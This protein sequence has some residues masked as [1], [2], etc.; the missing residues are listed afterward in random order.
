MNGKGQILVVNQDGSHVYNASNNAFC[1]RAPSWS[2]DGRQIA[3]V[4]S[5]DGDWEIYVMAADGTGQQR[6]TFSPGIDRNP[7]WS[8]DGKYIAFESDRRGSFDIWLMRPD[9]SGQRAV[10]PR[11]GNEYEPTWS[12]DSQSLAF[13]IQPV[14]DRRALCVLGIEDGASRTFFGPWAI[15]YTSLHSIAWSPDGKRIAGAFQGGKDTEDCNGSGV[16]V[17]N[18]DGGGHRELL[19]PDPLKPRSG[20][21]RSGKMLGSGWYSD[22]SASQ[23]WIPKRFSG[24]SWLP[25]ASAIVFSSDM[26]ESGDF[27]VYLLPVEGDKPVKLDGTRSAWPSH[28]S[29]SIRR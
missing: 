21:E 28:S 4:S 14:G 12:P 10:A 11:S 16:F 2:A 17:I 5:R 18:T 27:Y 7:R 15:R 1:D 9:G 8:P 24:V 26:D 19:K 23:R 29:A 20:G 22:Y 13:T 25:D 6:L 3:F